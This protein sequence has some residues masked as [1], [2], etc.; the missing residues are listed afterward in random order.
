MEG[1]IAFGFF[2]PGSVNT[3]ILDPTYG[4]FFIETKTLDWELGVYVTVKEIEMTS[5]SKETHPRYFDNGSPI[6]SLNDT[7]G[8]IT[9]KDFSEVVL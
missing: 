4:S 7:S 5:L 3:G 6:S 2:N 8:F 9:A 1:E